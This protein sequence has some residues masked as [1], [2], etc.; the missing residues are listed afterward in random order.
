MLAI[1]EMERGAFT[2][3]AYRNHEAVQD[4]DQVEGQT[5]ILVQLKLQHSSHNNT[6]NASKVWC[7]PNQCYFSIIIIY[8]TL[9]F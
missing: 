6:T 2:L 4:T 9:T 7:H 1:Q 8:N 3:S 5:E